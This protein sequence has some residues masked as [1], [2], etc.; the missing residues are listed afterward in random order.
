[1]HSQ[2]TLFRI[3]RLTL[4]AGA[5]V[6]I[7]MLPAPAKASSAAP[8]EAA[9]NE[10]QKPEDENSNLKKNKNKKEDAHEIPDPEELSKIE[11]EAG[12]ALLGFP[13]LAGLG[14][15]AAAGGI[16]AAAAGGGGGDDGDN[17]SSGSGGSPPPADGGNP[18]PVADTEAG[19]QAGLSTIKANDAHSRGFT[20]NGITI[21][22]LDSGIDT[23]HNEFSGRVTGC[24]NADTGE[25]GCGKIDIHWH[26]AHVAGIAAASR[27]NNGMMGVA[28]NSSI[29]NADIFVANGSGGQ[30]YGVGWNKQA[31]AVN[32][33]V[34]NG[35]KITNNS[36]G[37][38]AY[39]S[40]DPQNVLDAFN[41]AT[42][43]IGASYDNAINNGVIMVWAAGN[44]SENQPILPAALP[45]FYPQ[46][47][48]LW[49]AVTAVTRNGSAL[50]SYANKCGN[51]ASF[52]IAAPGSSIY[53][54]Y[55][56][57]MYAIASGTSMATPHVSGA[58]AVL[59]E[60]F[61]PGT[62]TN[63][64]PGEIVD[65]M[66]ATAN[67][68]G[69]YA[70]AQTYGQ[71]LLD[72]EKATRP[73]AATLAFP[74]AQGFTSGAQLASLTSIQLGHAFGD[75][76]SLAMAGK[77]AGAVDKYGRV[78]LI[79][80][81]GL[82]SGAA[83]ATDGR[84]LIRNFTGD[85][86]LKTLALSPRSSI[87][88]SFSDTPSAGQPPSPQPGKLSVK[89]E[90]G[91][92]GSLTIGYGFNPGDSL[93]LQAGGAMN[94]SLLAAMEQSVNPWF[95][96]A[97][98][99]AFSA[100]MEFRPEPGS[101][102]LSLRPATFFS[103]ET[104]DDPFYGSG[105]STQKDTVSGTALEA[106]YKTADGRL[107]IS[108]LSGSIRESE[109]VLGTQSSGALAAG[110]DTSTFF[111][112]PSASLAINESIRLVGTWQAGWTDVKHSSGSMLSDF[113]SFRSDS[114]TIGLT[115]NGVFKMS[116]EWGLLLHQPLRVNE[117]KATLTTAAGRDDNGQP[118]LVSERVTLTPSGREIN[119]QTFY[120]AN[121]SEKQNFSTGIMLRLEPGHNASADTETIAM[122][123]YRLKF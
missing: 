74:T 98:T 36:Y 116:D 70:D 122:A 77:Q 76:A 44:D 29:L 64:T 47:E 37:I 118:L 18:G 45:I 99:Q 3:A 58:L 25:E 83:A 109:N 61:G 17:S 119:I 80:L 120:S 102:G 68:S 33:I 72:L 55:S 51:A 30:I 121:I 78:F 34:A 57:N 97:G 13:A 87:S 8:D 52:C 14:G 28:Y 15:A 40:Y 41:P 92:K 16:A 46:W 11:P 54:A 63:K 101:G 104:K 1:M 5:A 100:G 96:F 67:K 73:D 66:F 94:R 9:R 53:S 93:G 43:A 123:R 111:A 85:D 86:D 103:N 89:N 112:G 20:G 79:D 105:P 31:D 19:A 21:G 62:P 88:F 84:R 7:F 69:I 65:L 90:I 115:G 48:D 114:F 60:A 35:A 38:L 49:V 117:A 75:A 113:S 6:N 50:A 32:W 91:S 10:E 22:F 27:N 110:G 59:L 107:N 42:T 12:P 95:D 71:G 24:F 26:A 106:G 23:G 39:D 82:S 108:V 4:L 2:S 81:G 56:G